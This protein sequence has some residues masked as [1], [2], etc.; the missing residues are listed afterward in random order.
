MEGDINTRGKQRG[1][2]L[3]ELLVVFSI[4]AI[5]S[6]LLIIAIDIPRRFA[7][8]DDVARMADLKT[9]LSAIHEYAI[10]NNGAIPPGL[11]PAEKQIGYSVSGC[12]NLN[13]GCDVLENACL[14]L[15]TTLAK[16]LTVFP[17]DLKT[18]SNAKTNYSVKIVSDVVTVKA[19]GSEG[20]SELSLSL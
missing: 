15:S 19:C 9:I 7:Q 12:V 6:S 4:L 8:A 1:F 5:L 10:E 3:F 16:Y 13:R 20:A 11:S 14:D 18:G 2:T 17:K